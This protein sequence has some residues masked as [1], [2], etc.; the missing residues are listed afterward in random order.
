VSGQRFRVS[1]DIGGTFTDGVL[2][3]EE[4]GETWIEKV[5]T[6]PGDP[7]EGFIRCLERLMERVPVTPEELHYVFHATTVA[8]NAVLQRRGARVGF[9][10]TR[11][12]RDILEIGRQI[13]WELY[14]LQ[15]EK[16]APLV[17]RQLCLEVPERLDYHGAV[18]EPLDEAAV[19][20]AVQALRA[21]S[22]EAIAVCFLH[23][24]RNPA[25]EQRAADVI[26]R[27]FPEARISLS[28]AIAPEIREYWRASTA[29]TNAYV[30]PI[31]AKYLE[32]IEH[33][34]QRKG[35]T[36][37]VRIMQSNGGV[38]TMATAKEKPVSMLESGPAA[39]VMAA[40]HFTK[41][42]GFKNGISFDMGGTTA[43]MGLVLDG[44]PKVASE[45][46]VGGKAGSGTGVAKGSGYPILAPVMDLVEVG[47]GGGSVAWI[48]SGGLL[49]VG[50]TSA[51]A[52]P[53][54]VC[55]GKGGSDPTVTDAHLVLGRLNP[56]Y[57]LGGEI[58]LDRDAAQR[59]VEERCSRPLGLN[60]V[61]AAIGIVDIANATMVD[62][63]RLVS[64]QRGYD[65]REF[66]LIAFGGMGPVHAN[67]LADELGI[68][69]VIVPPS[70]GVASAFGI[71]LT[72]L[73]R[74]YRVTR[75]QQV[76]HARLA[77]LNDVFLEF[78]VRA[79]GE[80]S[81]EG[82][83]PDEVTIERYLEMRYVGQSW[84]LRIPVHENELCPSDLTRLEEAFHQQH[85]Q[86][87]GYSVASEPVEVVTIGLSAIGHVPKPRLREIPNGSGSSSSARKACRP[88][89]FEQAADFLDCPIFD[90]YLL[91]RG[92]VVTGPAVIE[93]IDSTT[94]VHPGYAAEVLSHG[95]LLL[96]RV[97]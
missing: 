16:P 97:E 67:R 91:R 21:E 38:M 49:R 94:V 51:G 83:S 41:L 72:N 7:S 52:D 23:S 44:R 22:V 12:F 78:E 36:A 35:I 1:I 57:F 60:W 40:T 92:A 77:E 15:T 31:V 58:P 76:R 10:V 74:D 54:P 90:R 88:V 73:Q 5:P 26:R 89:F 29:V 50:P 2:I 30:A 24:Y 13:R 20:K 48:D 46:E 33:K 56:D 53:G 93:E 45:F 63:M 79:S 59:A 3:E 34:V 43:K 96:R 81:E 95:L 65:P 64:V 27:L 37:G 11:G 84:K 80:F 28:S 17:P 9:L 19:E 69:A 71:L 32:A 14:N 66:A 39:G 4:T 61:S 62:A 75:L 47:A 25:H 68:P 42:A 70:P 86:S 55:Y 87:Y 85:E 18:L 6:T 8:T 82:V